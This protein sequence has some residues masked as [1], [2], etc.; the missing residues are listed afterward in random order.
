MKTSTNKTVLISGA[1]FAGLS[2]AFWMSRLG[3]HVTIAEIAK[4]IK[5]GGSPVNIEGITVDI[6][7]KMGIYEQV[8]SNTITMELLEFKNADDISEGA[9]DRSASKDPHKAEG[10]EIERNTLLNLLYDLVK[11]TAEFIFSTSIT[12]LKESSDQI[13]V[14]F[15]NGSTRDFDLLLGCDGIHSPVR[16]ICFGHEHE[17]S[18]FLGQYFSIT[19][20]NKLLIPENTT[21]FFNI[22]DKSV[23]LNAYNGKTDI[24]F[25]FHSDNEIAYDY[26]DE[27]QQRQIILDQFAG[28]NWRTAELLSEMMESKNFYFDKFCQIKMP[29]WTKGRVALVGDAGYCASPA[30][31]M[32]GS[33]AINGAA[34]LADAFEKSEESFENA[35]EEYNKSFRPFL[36]EVQ[37][38]VST[39]SMEILFPRTEEAIRKRNTEGFEL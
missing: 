30:A 27:A 9:M 33:L 31:G 17:Y 37:E 15:N 16:R 26:R 2:A 4:G 10:F 5:L 19:I 35:F 22:P 7:R 12:G 29:S 36:T 32:G 18:H 38:R 1:S 11:N 14:T 21:Q 25:C 8:G 34:A 3:Y 23:M 6:I 39:K 24:I 20:I 28:V 13:S